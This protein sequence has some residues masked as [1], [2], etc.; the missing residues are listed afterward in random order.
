MLTLLY[1]GIRTEEAI[2]LTWKDIDLKNRLIYINK[3]IYFKNNQP[4]LKDVKTE[5]SNRSVPILLP[6][7]E[8]L[9]KHEAKSKSIYVFPSAQNKMMSETSLR[10]LKESFQL[11]CDKLYKEKHKDSIEK[12]LQLEDFHFTLHQFRHTCATMLQ[13][14]GVSPKEAQMWLGHSSIS[15]TMDIY[16]HLEDNYSAADKLNKF[17]GVK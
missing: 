12:G 1:S 9:K 8:I 13:K 7:L 15:V 4:E 17:L 6:L 3:A 14:A 10:R 16:T 11:A 5:N 2:P